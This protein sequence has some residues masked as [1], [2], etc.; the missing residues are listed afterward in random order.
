MIFETQILRIVKF[1]ISKFWGRIM[2]N[3]IAKIIEKVIKNMSPEF[4]KSLVEYTKLLEK[5]AATTDNPWDDILVLVLK[6]AIGINE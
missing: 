1:T 5:S 4:R 2:E 6:L 3:I